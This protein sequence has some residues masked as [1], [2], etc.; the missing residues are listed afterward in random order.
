MKSS[1]KAINIVAKVKM[2]A[3]RGYK[4]RF[5]SET[6]TKPGVYIESIMMTSLF[7]LFASTD[8]EVTKLNAKL[9]R[10]FFYL[11]ISSFTLIR[12]FFK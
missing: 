9:L 1:K 8:L 12:L 11:D 5:D 2:R 7:S 3:K 6:N 10:G 4:V